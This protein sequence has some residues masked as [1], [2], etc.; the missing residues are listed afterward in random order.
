M[1]STLRRTA[2]EIPLMTGVILP[3]SLNMRP[4][5]SS[6]D[7]AMH[8]LLSIGNKATIAVLMVAL[9]G[10][11]VG[12]FT[13]SLGTVMGGIRGRMLIKLVLQSNLL[14][15]AVHKRRSR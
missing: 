5:R 4:W 1:R 9:I 8:V 6:L 15:A 3:K 11:L 13:T 10:S 7:L 2:N 14:V 12:F